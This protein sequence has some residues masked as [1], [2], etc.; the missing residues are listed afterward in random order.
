[1]LNIEV[2]KRCLNTYEGIPINRTEKWG[3]I[4]RMLC[5]RKAAVQHYNTYNIPGSHFAIVNQPP[6]E[7]CPFTLEHIISEVDHVDEQRLA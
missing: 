1:M 7:W 3:R 5:P 6:P 4:D 2:C